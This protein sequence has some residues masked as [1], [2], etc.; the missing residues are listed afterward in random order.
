MSEKEPRAV[1][2]GETVDI[3]NIESYDLKES[4][5]VVHS[6][7]SKVLLRV[8]EMLN[9]KI[10]SSVKKSDDKYVDL[11][12]AKE[13]RREAIDGK[14]EQANEFI[15]GLGLK[16]IELS[17]VPIGIGLELKDSA[18]QKIDNYKE[19]WSDRKREVSGNYQDLKLGVGNLGTKIS[20]KAEKASNI[21][22]NG[23]NDVAGF[24]KTAFSNY[25]N[26]LVDSIKEGML[27]G[28]RVGKKLADN[29]DDKKIKAQQRVAGRRNK[30]SEK[31]DNYK[32]SGA[33]YVKE[34]GEKTKRL[35]KAGRMALNAFVATMNQEQK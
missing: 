24:F 10:D 18:T 32:N 4:A 22:R 9:D 27:E 26:R 20:S 11:L 13:D 21:V 30:W 16:A 34:A 17:L 31:I 3:N 12:A 7:F 19:D 8:S 14:I 35:P 25:R 2:V 23:A 15:S 5:E 29:L 1:N 28:E 33:N 6:P